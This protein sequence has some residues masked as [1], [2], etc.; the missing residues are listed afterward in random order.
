MARAKDETRTMTRK[1]RERASRREGIID[2]AEALFAAKG[3]ENATMDEIAEKA[4]FGKPTLYSY[5]KSKDEIL[6]LVHM[7]KHEPKIAM[8]R[9]A[10]A[11]QGTG[12]DKLRALGLAYYQFYKRNPEYLRMQIYWDHKGLAFDR[13]GAA[14]R[15]QYEQLESAF[16][17]F[18]G[19]IRLGVRDGT[20]RDGLDVE[21]TLDL[22]FLLMRTVMNQV[23]LVEPPSVS[24]LEENSE[25]AYLYCLDLFLESVR[26]RRRQGR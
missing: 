25:S 22:F 20:I 16:Y 4:E 1:E 18:A 13:F 6:F 15:G 14:V 19:I 12:V 21:Q 2:A 7:R 24:Q 5:F 8:L 3:F 11:K 9:Q 17:E 10:V 23:I 26:A